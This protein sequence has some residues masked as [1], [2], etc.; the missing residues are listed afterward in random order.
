M[1]A[2]EANQRSKAKPDESKHGQELYQNAG[3]TT[4][5]MLLISK[6]AGV[7][8]NDT[9]GYKSCRVETRQKYRY[10]LLRG[11]SMVPKITTRRSEDFF[12]LFSVSMFPSK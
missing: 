1:R 10:I 8:A 4:A 2:K 9:L 7:L 5:A 3:E 12:S 11:V 6:S